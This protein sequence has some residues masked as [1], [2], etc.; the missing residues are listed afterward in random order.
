MSFVHSGI[1]WLAFQAASVITLLGTNWAQ[2]SQRFPGNHWETKLPS[3]LQ[4]DP[5]LLDRFAENVGG[6]GCVV[7]DGYLV[8]SWG[9]IERHKDWASAAKPVLSTLLLLSV[10]EKR[11]A[12]VDAQV[13]DLGWEMS[14]KDSSMTYRHLANMVSGYALQEKPGEAWSY[15]DYAIQLYA[16]SLERIFDESLDSALRERLKSLQFEDGEFFG[17]RNGTGVTASSRDFARLGWLWLNRGQWAGLQVLNRQL[18][19]D[20]FR[21]GVPP[22]TLRA[23]NHTDDYL[24]IGSYGGS[25]N[26]T[27]SGPGVYGFNLWFNAELETGQRVWPALPADAYQANG[28][29]NRDTLT[30]IPSWNMVIA[31]R[32]A[33]PGK[34]EPGVAQGE[35]NRNLQL[36]ARSVGGQV[37]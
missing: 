23:S 20:C 11:I 3:D 36:I 25:T 32:G 15:N 14:A 29:W 22:G 9:N 10:Q 18:F 6:D 4:M 34:F 7:R 2:E 33:Q 35:Y 17:S 28:L 12:S 24:K 37:D 31:S 19:D 27:A 21:V 8:K 26:Q 16:K 5:E 13:V 1:V 30:V